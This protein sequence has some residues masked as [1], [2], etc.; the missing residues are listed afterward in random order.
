[1]GR[2]RRYQSSWASQNL[3]YNLFNFNFLQIEKANFEEMDLCNML[4][5]LFVKL[6]FKANLRLHKVT[7][8][9]WWCRTHLC[10]RAVGSSET[11]GGGLSCNVVGIICPTPAWIGFKNLGRPRP[12]GTSTPTALCL[13]SS[14]FICVNSKGLIFFDSL[15]FIKSTS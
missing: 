7:H 15:K 13:L 9:W 11:S 5:A 4:F 6:L 10:L 12:I 8:C 3:L 2:H 1:M 14:T